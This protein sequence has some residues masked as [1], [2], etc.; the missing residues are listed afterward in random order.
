[1]PMNYDYYWQGRLLPAARDFRLQ[2]DSFDA[3]L[4]YNPM[5]KA[6]RAIFKIVFFNAFLLF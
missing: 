1:M 2:A 6:I 4:G 3:S 5:Y